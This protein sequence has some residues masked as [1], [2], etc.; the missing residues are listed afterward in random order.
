VE[1]FVIGTPGDKLRPWCRDNG[2]PF[3]P[4]PL[5]VRDRWH[6]LRWWR[7]VRK[8]RSLLRDLRID[9]VHANQIWCYPA[10]GTAA[11]ALGL[12]RVCHLRDEVSQEGLRWWC[13]AGVEAFVCISRHIESQVSGAWP[14]TQRAPLVQTI[15][16]P[17]P[18]PALPEPRAREHARRN[19]RQLLGIDE[20]NV[21][22]GFVGQIIPVKGLPELL[23]A[24]SKLSR[25]APWQLVVAGRD[26][27]P[28][29][30]HEKACRQR[31]R[32][33]G[34]DRH[35][36]FLGFLD[37]VSPFYQAI[38]IAVVPSLEEPLG[39]VPLE[40]GAHGRPAIAYATGG[41]PE[42]IR[43]GQTGWLIAP[44][45]VPALGEAL[46]RFLEEPDRNMGLA[47][48]QWVESVSDPRQYAG[49]LAC[50]YRRLLDGTFR[51]LPNS[52]P[53]ILAANS[54]AN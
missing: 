15:L 9:L 31:V 33:L 7:S 38:D 30:P 35:V 24:L 8:M 11:R 25:V 52:T 45:D 41:L 32:E 40:A 17:V 48:R 10:A 29:A 42:T 39:R 50:L 2:I 28:G 43:Q 18:M 20:N 49:K 51:R 26:P 14:S 44:G 5:A 34:L 1:P 47:A 23:E 46:A 53:S 27:N 36:K 19:A 37:D 6:P 4:C 54:S 12:P 3:H 21:V 13:A 16:N 22:F